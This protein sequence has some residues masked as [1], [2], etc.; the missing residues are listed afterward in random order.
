MANS[1]VISSK[2]Q[3]TI[4]Q[5]VRAR[6]GLKEGDRLEFVTEGGRTV[7]RP[8]RNHANPFDRYIG[9]LGTFA[10]EAEINAWVRELRDNDATGEK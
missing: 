7:I 6:L 4:P 5:E 1:S 8:A 2:G 9:A 10:N 3:V